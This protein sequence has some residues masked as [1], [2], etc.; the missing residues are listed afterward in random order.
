MMKRVL[1]TAAFMALAPLMPALTGDEALADHD[2]VYISGGISVVA[3]D[4]VLGFSYGNPYVVGH[5]HH[6]PVYCNHGPIYYYPAYKV[7]GHYHPRYTYRY[8]AKP[9][10]HGYY[11]HG[12]HARHGHHHGYHGKHGYRSGGHRHYDRGDDDRDRRGRQGHRVRGH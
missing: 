3:P 8:Y 4:S 7:Y 9:H 12:Y 10:G 5:V 1:S 11:G 6:E 2:G